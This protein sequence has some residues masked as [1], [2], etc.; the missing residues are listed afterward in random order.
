ML[1]PNTFLVMF[2]VR[3]LQPMEELQVQKLHLTINNFQ[4]RMAQQV[5]LIWTAK[6]RSNWKELM[7]SVRGS[8]YKV[9]SMVSDM[10]K[11]KYSSRKCAENKIMYMQKQNH[12]FSTER[13]FCVRMVI[14]IFFVTSSP[15]HTW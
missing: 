2:E 12:Y 11:I 4:A 1:E 13:I 6:K 10:A 5:V 3:V 9:S 8:T 15:V 7:V 14:R